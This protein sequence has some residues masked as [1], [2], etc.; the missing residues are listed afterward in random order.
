DA[1]EVVTPRRRC[2]N[3]CQDGQQRRL[4]RA[5][6][7]DDRYVVAAVD[8][9]VGRVEGADRWRPA[10]GERDSPQ[11]DQRP[12]ACGHHRG[13]PPTVTRSPTSSRPD[14]AATTT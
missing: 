14:V 4:S 11:P 7:A 3:E 1:V 5:G 2:V 9:E 10:I 13:S 8:V 12:V 6:A